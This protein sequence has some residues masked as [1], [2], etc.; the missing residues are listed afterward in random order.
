MTG[1]QTC[2]LPISLGRPVS[3]FVPA[4]DFIVPY[5]SSDLMTTPRATH[6][7]RKYKNDIRKLQVSGYYVDTD[8]G[9]PAKLADEFKRKIDKV[10]GYDSAND[11]RFTLYEVCV[12]LDIPE[13]RFANP[14]G[15]EIPYV[16]TLLKDSNKVL[17]IRRNWEE[18]DE[19]KTPRQHYVHYIYI[20]G[21]G[22]YGL[23][24]LHLLG[25]YASA[26]T[27]I[28]RQLVDSG[29]LSNL[30]G[31][32]KTIGLRIKNDDKIGRAHV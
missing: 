13:D 8:I 27:S 19:L 29:T 14:D 12:C 17:A 5:G 28:I 6:R 18:N 23:G 20:P 1:V 24:L 26:A 3:V 15:I 9:D 11:D 16:V 10:E 32:L 25:N 4:E 2:A 22:F 31:G 21:F 7:Q 30:P